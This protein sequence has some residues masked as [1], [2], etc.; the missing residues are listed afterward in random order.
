M[1]NQNQPS[2]GG[3]TP[4]DAERPPVSR[5]GDELQ[6]RADDESVPEDDDRDVAQVER[7]AFESAQEKGWDKSVKD[8]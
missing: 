2:A 5:V 6:Q 1:T 4:A 7:E 8:T 3:R